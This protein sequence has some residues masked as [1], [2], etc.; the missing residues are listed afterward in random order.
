MYAS[1]YFVIKSFDKDFRKK[2]LMLIFV[3]G[4]II[5]LAG[6]AQYFLY[7]NL[8]NLYY[9]GWD[10]HNYRMFSVFLDPNFAG[11]FFVLFFLLTLWLFYNKDSNK[12]APLRL[13]AALLSVLCLLAVFLTYSRS[14][15]LMLIA[16]TITYFVLIKKKIF[17]ILL[18]IIIA[19]ALLMLSPTFNKEN[20]NPLRVTSSFARIDSYNNA[21]K[22][23]KDHSLL[24]VGFNTYRYALQSYGLRSANTQFPNHADAGVDNSFLF[25][26]ATTGLVGL[27]A[28]LFIWAKL[29]ETQYL[30]IGKYSLPVVFVASFAGLTVNAFFINSLFYAPIM[31]WMW[32]IA[33]LSGKD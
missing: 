19:V 4:L 15:I 17:L 3:D 27:A 20:T 32:I 16:S 24:G 29:L 6:F 14:A 2:I 21:F 13:F 9:L 10:E 26:F 7:P 22:I 28:Y 25:I 12:E 31:L 30:L 18:P 33:G 5:L 8:R 11:A 23:I 1:I